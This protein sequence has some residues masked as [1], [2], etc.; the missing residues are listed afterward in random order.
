YTKY[1]F[2]RVQRQPP[3]AGIQ[4]VEIRT[5]PQVDSASLHADRGW[6][7]A[8]LA[9]FGLGLLSKPM[10]VTVPFVLLLLDLWPLGRIRKAPD[11]LRA[12]FSY[13]GIL[14]E[15]VPFFLFS[16]AVAV[17]TLLAQ[18]GTMVSLQNEAAI[19][20]VGTVFAGYFLYLQKT[21][22]PQN[23]T[24]LY[25]RPDHIPAIPLLLGLSVVVGISI[26]A[27]LTFR[28]RP[29]LM[30]GW[31]WF[32]GMLA[33]VNGLAQTGLQSMADRYSYLPGIGLAILAVWGLHE[34]AAVLPSSR[35][36]RAIPAALACVVLI[37]CANASHDQL[38]YWQ[39][40]KTLMEHALEIDPNN[41]VA[42]QDLGRYYGKLGQIELARMH[43]QKVFELDPALAGATKN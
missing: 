41:Y 13:D 32:L 27:V 20:R 39:N 4:A 37:L 43:H 30:I 11:Q 36:R 22:W 38:R 17:I 29:Y 9:F 6:Y 40:T 19:T 10:L 18:H 24:V 26:L 16:A 42:H 31:F 15:K 34:L 5:Q 2:S 23:L 21:L 12:L 7:V 33:P 28:T 14:V 25:L 8:T 35:Y 3:G 1:T